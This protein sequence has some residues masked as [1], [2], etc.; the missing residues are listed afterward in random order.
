V[1][2]RL[3]KEFSVRADSV[4]LATGAKSVNPFPENL[5]GREAEIYSIGDARAPR[6]VLEAVAEGLALGGKI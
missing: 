2:E 4:I 3:G 5:R 6:T 1:V